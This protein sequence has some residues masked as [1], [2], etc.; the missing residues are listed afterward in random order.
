[1]IIILE[2]PDNTGKT[3]LGRLL[4]NS[5][6]IPFKE[7]EGREKYMGEMSER[8]S[9]WLT[10][11]NMILDRHPVISQE[12]YATIDP[13]RYM[14]TDLQKNALLM[15]DKFII[16]CQ[17]NPSTGMEGHVD[18]KQDCTDYLNALNGGYPQMCEV[19]DQWA[20]FNADMIYRKGITKPQL[21]VDAV[22]GL[23][24]V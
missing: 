9:R 17:G 22:K 24:N 19:Y 8:I 10:Y 5:T 6:G 1:M 21:V 23:M 16:Y 14:P 20:R 7:S 15:K 3:T 12:I 4:C 13:E 18:D 11:D 2:G